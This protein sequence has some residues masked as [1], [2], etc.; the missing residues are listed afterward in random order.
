M[1][2]GCV[3]NMNTTKNKCDEIETKINQLY[4]EEVSNLI[5]QYEIYEHDLHPNVIEA[6]VIL[7]QDFAIAKSDCSEKK[8]ELMKSVQSQLFIIMRDLYN[9]L[10][11]TY[12]KKIK[13]Y[14]KFNRKF[15]QRGV[16]VDK[17]D[18]EFNFKDITEREYSSIR[19]EVKKIKKKYRRAHKE[20]DNKENLIEENDLSDLAST[21][22]RL[23]K[24]LDIYEKYNSEVVNSGYSDTIMSK[25]YNKSYAFVSILL[26][27]IAFISFLMNNH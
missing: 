20:M 16:F 19:K 1:D 25:L 21:Y 18:Q 17:N 10:I 27:V 13:M 24:L 14:R 26:A 12:C 3:F 23:R 7:F 2:V 4:T 22:N 9:M 11:K 15:N 8:Y 6:I 5:S